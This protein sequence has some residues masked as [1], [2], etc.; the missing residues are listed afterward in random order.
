M[1]ETK[2]SSP[3]KVPATKKPEPSERLSRNEKSAKNLH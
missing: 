2:T 3:E 1:P